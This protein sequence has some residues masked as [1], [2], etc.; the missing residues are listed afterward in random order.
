MNIFVVPL[1]QE[2]DYVYHKRKGIDSKLFYIIKFRLIIIIA[3]VKSILLKK[4][5]KR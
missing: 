3:K 1:Q 2:Y 5:R 4:E